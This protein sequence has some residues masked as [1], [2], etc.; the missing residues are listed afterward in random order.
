VHCI[1]IHVLLIY[2]DVLFVY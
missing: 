2:Y 1:V